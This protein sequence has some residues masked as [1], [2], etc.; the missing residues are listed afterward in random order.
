MPFSSVARRYRPFVTHQGAAV[1]S[2]LGLLA[3]GVVY[4]G[5]PTLFVVGLPL[6]IAALL[7]GLQSLAW[8]RNAAGYAA[9]VLG[10]IA[11]LIPVAQ[12]A[13]QS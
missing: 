13:S 5:G 2:A 12:F 3:V 9:S 11:L 7:L 8:Q 6:A 10:L 4:L 1:G